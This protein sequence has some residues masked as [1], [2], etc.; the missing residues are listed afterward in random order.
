MN[1]SENNELILIILY[2]SNVLQEIKNYIKN[3]EKKILIYPT[4]KY[5]KKSLN[6][7][8]YLKKYILNKIK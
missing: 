4:N 2:E 6:Q 7:D 5:L 1:I 3:K 8:N